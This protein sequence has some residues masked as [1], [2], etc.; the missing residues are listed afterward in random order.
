MVD[1]ETIDNAGYYSS[2]DNVSGDLNGKPTETVPDM[3]PASTTDKNHPKMT[4]NLHYYS[5][6]DFT[7]SN[8]HCGA[9]PDV[10]SIVKHHSKLS[11]NDYESPPAMNTYETPGY[12]M[13][14]ESCH[15]MNS[16][17]DNVT[18][19]AL[20][21]DEQIYEDP[22][23]NEEK[24]YVWFEEKKFRRIR[25]SDIKYVYCLFEDKILSYVI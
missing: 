9:T 23:H 1:Y 4:D 22:G 25:E 15:I 17:E 16:T 5:S 24:I 18:G 11:N 7:D 10:N 14:D 2:V 21:E 19:E 20:P 12:E 3:K 13:P 8:R 6:T